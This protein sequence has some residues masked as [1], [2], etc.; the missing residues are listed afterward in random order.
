MAVPK[1]ARENMAKTGGMPSHGVRSLPSLFHSPDV[2][3]LAD[4]TPSE[5]D[6]KRMGIEASNRY[7]EI[8]KSQEVGALDKLKGGF[9]R[10]FDRISAGNIDAP[11]SRAYEQYGAGLGKTEYENEQARKQSIIDSELARKEYVPETG[12]SIA[13]RMG[14]V[15]MGPTVGEA[16]TEAAPVT[17]TDTTQSD[18]ENLQKNSSANTSSS[19]AASTTDGKVFSKPTMVTVSKDKA[20]DKS[21]QNAPTLRKT[22]NRQQS[23]A[24]RVSSTNVTQPQP[25]APED[26]E[27]RKSKSGAKGGNNDSS[28]SR[29]TPI[30]TSESDNRPSKPYPTDAK[31]KSQSQG[32]V[33]ESDVQKA[34]ARY[35]ALQRTLA[36]APKNTSATAL[37]ALKDDLEYARRDYEEKAKKLKR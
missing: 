3:H 35:A 11:G 21:G 1:W 22:N 2:K 15:N 8:E 20:E 36:N 26:N 12:A 18:W 25:Q 23:S 32:S 14:K 27:S 16:K 33:S 4:G 9:S 5:D 37:K 10:L 28:K 19:S 30:K 13:A 6:F 24:R 34:G 17:K 7:N 31:P 29:Q